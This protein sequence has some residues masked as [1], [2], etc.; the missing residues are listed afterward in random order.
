MNQIKSK[1][2]KK[3]KKLE[4]EY[5]NTFLG[6]HKKI[7]KELK[8]EILKI[9]IDLIKNIS[10]DYKLDYNKLYHQ[11]IDENYKFD[12]DNE[13]NIKI[14]DKSSELVLDQV[15]INGK[16]YYQDPDGN[17]Y[18]EN[19]KII[20]TNKDKKFKSLLTDV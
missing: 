5:H 3:L 19:A 2:I 1:S 15:I 9:K 13:N 4:T 12:E 10:I 8:N 16:T 17:I 18:D 7:K 20:G 6:I 11:Y 14:Q